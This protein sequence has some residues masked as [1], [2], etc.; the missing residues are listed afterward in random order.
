MKLPFDDS[1]TS[2]RQFI[3]LERDIATTILRTIEDGWGLALLSPDVNTDT[4]EIKLTERLR[5]GMRQAVNEGRLPWHATMVVLPGTESRSG[6]E[7]LVPDGRTDIPIFWIEIF[8]R[9][10]EHD[11]HAIIECKRIDGNNTYLCREYV[12]EGI[13]RFRKGKYSGNHSTGFMIGYLI[14][15]DAKVAVTGIN[16]NLNRTSRSDENLKP[17]DLVT[18]SWVWASRHPRKDTLP[19]ELYHAF[20]A[21]AAM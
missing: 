7:V 8:L 4:G 18:E 19:I 16:K 1:A 11:P 9:F 13:D 2:G 12:V 15:G 21:F 3:D 6:P 20:L 10:G 14:A 17:S 5:D